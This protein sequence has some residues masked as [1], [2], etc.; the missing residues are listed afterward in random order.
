MSTQI[1]VEVVK[2]VLEKH[3]NADSLSIAIIKGGWRCIVRTDDF[4]NGE[5]GAYIPIDSIVPNTSDFKFIWDRNGGK[6]GRIKTMKLRGIVSQGLLIV[7]KPEWVEG[8]DV[9]ELLGITKYEPPENIALGGEQAP[10][11]AGFDK[12]T[13]I[14]NIKN[15][16]GV[17]KTNDEVVCTEKV[18]GTNFRVGIINGEF[19]VGSHNTVKIADG[20]NVYSAIARE[21]QLK[22]KL[23]KFIAEAPY[24]ITSV[25]LYG[26]IYGTG[27]Q[28]L[29]YGEAKPR[30]RFFDIKV[31]GVYESYRE[32]L[33]DCDI[34]GVESMPVL[35]RG[36]FDFDKIIELT[37]GDTVVSDTKQMREGL[38]I[39]TV[40]EQ[41]SEELCDRKVLKSI[42]EK[43]LLRKKGT[44]YH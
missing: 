9:T 42:S 14:Q 12:Y 10:N 16:V 34:I 7:A 21:Y 38:V 36:K 40:F 41:F 17:M 11:V 8:Q 32:F 27:I 35:Y 25:I 18:H 13:D 30:V 44:E 33:Y 5:L 24:D 20:K 2:P 15:F 39:R 22:E 29:K 3:P 37:E 31:N 26:E 43:Y 4:S 19:C 28:D 1:K 6:H 23:E